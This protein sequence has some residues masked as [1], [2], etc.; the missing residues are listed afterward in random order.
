MQ[1]VGI[2]RL[3]SHF[4]HGTWVDL[5]LNHL[6]HDAKADVFKPHPTFSLVDARLLG[7]IATSV[8]D[9]VETY[10]ECY[11]ATLEWLQA[12]VVDLR[13]RIREAD[14]VHEKLVTG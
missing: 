7:P 9:A 4:V 6:Q 5:C 12:R 10:L 8:L 2:Q 14:S 1:Y 3:P 11:F 13:E